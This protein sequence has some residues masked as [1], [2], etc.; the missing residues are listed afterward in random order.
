MQVGASD[1]EISH[2]D[3]AAPLRQEQ[4]QIAHQDAFADSTFS[5]CDRN[6]HVT[7]LPFSGLSGARILNESVCKSFA[8][9]SVREGRR[10]GPSDSSF[11]EE[12]R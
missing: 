11:I 10:G 8:G 6:N 7:A 5:R 4:A 1:I 2:H 9:A 3:P 12:G